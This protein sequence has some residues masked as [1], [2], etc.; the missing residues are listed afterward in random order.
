MNAPAPDQGR[1]RF[2]STLFSA[3]DQSTNTTELRPV[4]ELPNAG[5]TVL[6]ALAADA[7]DNIFLA[8][9]DGVIFHYDGESWQRENFPSPLNIHSLCIHHDKVFSVGWMGQICIRQDGTWRAMQ[10]GGREPETTNQPLFDIAA[11]DNG[12]LWAVGDNGRVSEYKVDQWLEHDS[13]TAGNLRVVLPLSSGN[14]LVGGLGGTVLEYQGESWRAITTGT[15]CPIVSMAEL[16]DGQVLAVGG[17]YCVD[18]NEFVGRIFLYHKGD[19]SAV[20]TD[21]PLPRLRRVRREGNGLIIVGDGGKAFRWTS[22]GVSLLTTR[23][24][25]DLHDAVCLTENQVLIC[26]DNGALLQE[27]SGQTG[28]AET[29]APECSPWMVISQAETK[30]TLRTLWAIDDQHLIAAGDG[31]TV[32]HIEGETLTLSNT[33]GKLRIHA[34][35]GSTPTNIYAVCDDATIVHYDGHNWE[36]AHKGNSDTA[37][38]AITGFGPHDIFAVGDNGYALRYDGLMWR[39]I[40]TGVKQELYALWGQDSQH[41]LA[42][43]GGGLVMRFD[44]ERWKQFTAGTD[45]DLYGVTGSGLNKLFLCGLSGTLIRFEDNAWHREF[46]GVR[47]DLHAV[48]SHD[49]NY[50]AVGSNGTVLSNN[51]GMWDLEDSGTTHTLQAVVA[52]PHHVWAVGSGGLVLRR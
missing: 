21:Y 28:A 1:R 37:L 46:T 48:D 47:S 2:L 3:A 10:G 29:T 6:W 15:G 5:N 50:Y 45:Y 39:E 11:A 22:E 24:R 40:E 14:V 38:L 35:W 8:G 23:V 20:T 41:L 49:G 42:V 44:G 30:K 52:T 25:Y 31:G 36:V 26:G 12:T 32:V 4:S 16:P 9:D 17:E 27:C 51:N 33:P 18:T 19:W 34:L 43:G 7:T 13:G